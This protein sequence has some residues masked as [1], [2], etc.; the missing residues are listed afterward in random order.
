MELKKGLKLGV[1]EQVSNADY[2]ADRHYLSSSVLKLLLKD[3]AEYERQ[4]LLGGA[5]PVMGNQGALDEGSLAHTRILEPHLMSTDY[6][7]YPGAIKRG[8]EFEKWKA[9]LQN[10]QLPAISKP[11]KDRSDRMIEAYKRLP[12]ATA[13]IEN[14]QTEYTICAELAGVPVKVRLDATQ[15]EKGIISDVKTTGH[16]S[17][18]HSF[19]QTCKDFDYYLSGA[20]YS[21]VAEQHFGRP[22]D[23]YF[24]VLSK[25]D[26]TCDVYRIG[27]EKMAA[28]KQKVYAALQLYKKCKESGIWALENNEK[29]A[30]N[31]LTSSSQ[32]EIVDL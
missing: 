17:D 13:L 6:N 15:L 26:Y 22:F 20:L 7:Y 18:L 21:M 24:I 23:F 4:Y 8:A 12:A 31:K 11:Q 30:D 9:T 10:P 27:E 29:K 1:N 19:L 25:R 2:H 14:A 16:G 3:P 28:A 32:Y 5:R